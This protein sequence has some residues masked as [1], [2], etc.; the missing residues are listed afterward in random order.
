MSGE[1]HCTSNW[2]ATAR[3]SPAP[4]CCKLAPHARRAEGDLLRKLHDLLSHRDS[5]WVL[6]KLVE[7]REH[8]ASHCQVNL[9]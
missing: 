7:L 8:L 1:S 6:G 9:I 3:G 5:W 2:L 4:A